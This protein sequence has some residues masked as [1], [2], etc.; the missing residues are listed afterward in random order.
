MHEQYSKLW[1]VENQ[2]QYTS[3]IP[4]IFKSQLEPFY[5]QDGSLEATS[6]HILSFQSFVK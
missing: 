1:K 6:S 4:L 5:I 3:C 2:E